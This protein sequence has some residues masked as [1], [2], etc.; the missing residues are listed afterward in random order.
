MS[1][2][3]FICYIKL[4][5]LYVDKHTSP[6][7]LNDVYFQKFNLDIVKNK[8]KTSLLNFVIEHFN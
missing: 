8:Y 6:Y 4:I 7:L 2:S 3:F 1:S 5:T